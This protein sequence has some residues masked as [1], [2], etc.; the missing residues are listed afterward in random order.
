MTARRSAGVLAVALV[1]SA[2]IVS[3]ASAGSTSATKVSCPSGTS[4]TNGLCVAR[5]ATSHQAA[6]A[7]QATFTD[8]SLGA[9]V[10]GV[11]RDGKPLVVGALGQSQTD[12]P[13]TVDMRHRAGNISAAMLTTAFLQQVDKGKLALDDKLSQWYPDLPAAD[14]VTLEMLARST[15]GYQHYPALE[16]FQKA[17]YIDPFKQWD[18]DDVIAYGVAG[19]PLFTPGTNFNFSDTNLLILSQVLAKAT[20]TSVA[21]L[22]QRGVL[23]RLGM[24]HTTPPVNSELPEPVLHSFTNERGVW[25]EATYWNPTWTWYAG[26]MASNQADVQKFIEALGTGALVSKDSHE[27]QLAPTT[28][29][30]GTNTPDRFY[31]MGMPVV[32]GWLFTNPGLQ[33]YRGAIGYYPEEKLTIVVYNTITPQA[34][35]DTAAATL[36]LERITALL[37]PDHAV[38]LP[39]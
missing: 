20:G 3:G 19:G 14:Q 18:T 12:V 26:G 5:D 28:A 37:T 16:S 7:V 10:V 29:S 1:V 9:V 11:W 27:A 24:T 38:E 36:I 35:P 34:D 32:N 23:D 17:F 22:I 13:A 6:D 4:A 39:A 21:K 2:C 15:S 33:G 25:E 30:L 31:A 8:Q